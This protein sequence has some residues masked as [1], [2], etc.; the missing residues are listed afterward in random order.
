MYIGMEWIF[1]AIMSLCIIAFICGI[2]FGFDF[3]GQE[4][5]DEQD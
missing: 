3:D 4:K 1:Y 5:K 2:V